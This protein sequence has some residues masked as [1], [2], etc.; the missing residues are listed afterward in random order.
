MELFGYHV[1]KLR[2]M[3]FQFGGSVFDIQLLLT[4]YVIPSSSLIL[5]DIDILLSCVQA[6]TSVNFRFSG[7]HLG[8]TTDAPNYGLISLTSIVCKSFESII[9]DYIVQF[10]VVNNL[11]RS[12]R[13]GF[14]TGRSTVLQLLKIFNDWTEMLEHGGQIDVIYIDFEK[15]F[16]RVPHNRL[17]I[18]L[19]SYNINED[20]I[21]WIKTYLENRVQRV[22]ITSCFSNWANVVSG[23]PQGVHLLL[24][25]SYINELPDFCDS[26]SNLFVR[27]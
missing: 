20:I 5:P 8:F 17:I 6:A 26:D 7:C 13:Y 25:I 2:Y 9:R 11:F 1:H 10:V 15:A 14:I 4:R 21:K 16:D 12:K 24:L 18:K 27:R 3:Y 19:F 23:I 22:K